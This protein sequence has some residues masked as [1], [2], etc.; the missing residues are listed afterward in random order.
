M[1]TPTRSRGRVRQFGKISSAILGFFVWLA[2][3]LFASPGLTQ[4]VVLDAKPT[5]KV[6]S[7]KDLTKRDLL[8]NTDQEK[9]RVRIIK[10]GTRY[11][12]A[13]RENRELLHELSGAFHLFVDPRGGG[14]VKV[15][16]NTHL[17]ESLRETGERFQYMEHLTLWLGTITYW[18]TVDKFDP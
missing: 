9:Y 1:T 5:V 8:S 4:I 11:L 18:G 14:Y 6:E 16:D 17:P 3:L 13:S 12:W 15:F 7:S 10:N 2:L